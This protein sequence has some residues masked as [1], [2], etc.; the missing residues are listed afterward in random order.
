MPS[1]R[2]RKVLRDLWSSKARTLLVVL[3]IAVGVFAVGSITHMN[4]IATRDAA[5]SYA[6]VLPADAIVNFGSGFD[7]ELLETVRRMD[8]VTAADGRQARTMRRWSL[9]ATSWAS[10]TCAWAN[11]TARAGGAGGAG[12]ATW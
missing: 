2:W 11:P 4:I 7:D 5:E 1:P 8:G 6:L 9:R 3:S 10:T 12:P